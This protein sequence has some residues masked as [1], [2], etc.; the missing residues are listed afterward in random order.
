MM[1]QSPTIAVAYLRPRASPAPSPFRAFASLKIIFTAARASAAGSSPSAVST[2]NTT[3]ASSSVAASIARLV[4]VTAHDATS[5]RRPAPFLVHAVATIALISRPSAPPRH[6]TRIASSPSPSRVVV[7]RARRRA[8]RAIASSTAS[9]RARSDRATSQSACARVARGM[10]TRMAIDPRQHARRRA[11][12][13]K[14]SRVD[15]SASARGVDVCANS[16]GSIETS[17]SR[18]RRACVFASAALQWTRFE[19]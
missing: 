2:T 18:R 16:H 11:R 9:T 19:G 12:M 3:V 7:R 17:T 4:A 1:S 13:R 15:R 8:R 14:Q 10:L 5:A 6:T